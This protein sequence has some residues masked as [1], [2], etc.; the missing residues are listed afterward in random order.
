MHTGKELEVHSVEKGHLSC[1]SGAPQVRSARSD[2]TMVVKLNLLKRT[3][4]KRYPTVILESGVILV[5]RNLLR[6][7]RLFDICFCFC[8]SIKKQLSFTEV[9]GD[10]Y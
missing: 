6:V 10:M 4:A 1:D 7:E 5:R 3:V 8:L 9:S 2:S